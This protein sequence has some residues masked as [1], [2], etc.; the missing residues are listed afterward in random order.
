MGLHIHQ[1]LVIQYGIAY[2]SNLYNGDADEFVGAVKLPEPN[3]SSYNYS[4][5]MILSSYQINLH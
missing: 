3:D 1:L 4:Q 5:V 2:G